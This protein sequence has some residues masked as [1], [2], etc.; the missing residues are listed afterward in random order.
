VLELQLPPWAANL[1]NDYWLEIVI[2]AFIAPAVAWLVRW[3]WLGIWRRFV[4]L[5]RPQPPQEVSPFYH[6]ISFED[7]K[8]RI[9]E[10]VPNLQG[11]LQ[12]T[13]QARLPEPAQGDF[14]DQLDN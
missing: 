4:P 11:N 5:P 13:Y 3:A 12:I 10:L 2:S 14:Q 6:A 9:A 7:L 1:L 8:A